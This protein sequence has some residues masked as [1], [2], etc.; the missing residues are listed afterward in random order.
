MANTSILNA[1]ERMWFHIVALVGNKADIS[2]THTMANIDNLQTTLDGKAS[3]THTHT[4]ASLGISYG[5]KSER[6]TTGTDGQIYLVI[7]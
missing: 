4:L 1:F 2:H 7:E 3:S 5:P 6:P